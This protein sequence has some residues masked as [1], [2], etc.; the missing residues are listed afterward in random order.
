M[1]SGDLDGDIYWINWRG[2]F[3]AN[4]QEHPPYSKIVENSESDS[5]PSQSPEEK[6]IDFCNIFNSSSSDEDDCISPFFAR[7]ITKE[8]SQREQYIENFIN[9]IKNDKLGEVANLHSKI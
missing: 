5:L 8:K 1:A 4:Y 9:Y 2:E 3:V 7:N 6:K